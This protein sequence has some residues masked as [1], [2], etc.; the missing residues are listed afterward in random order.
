MRA[1]PRLLPEE[2]FPAYAYLPGASPHPTR[3]P[4]G[5]SF[6][7]EAEKPAEH[8]P[9]ER[10][11]TCAPYLF[12]VD[13][14]NAGYLWEAHEA[15][16]SLWHVS[17]HDPPQAQFIQGL[18]Q[19]TA[20]ALKVRMGQ[21]VGVERLGAQGTQRLEETARAV[22]AHYMGLD[23]LDFV[24]EVREFIAGSPT[25]SEDRPMIILET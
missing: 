14:Y 18:I 9:P 21:P 8:C 10:W 17:K 23:V 1:P 6:Q 15:W 16:E 3:D 2:P 22:G 5:H 7:K 11:A 20:A 4:E 13:L 25:D 19:C 12:G 24:R